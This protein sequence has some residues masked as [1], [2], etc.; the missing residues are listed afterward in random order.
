MIH[1]TATSGERE[2]CRCHGKMS[3]RLPQYQE[4]RKKLLGKHDLPKKKKKKKGDAIDWQRVYRE[5]TILG[6]VFPTGDAAMRT[7][8]GCQLASLRPAERSHNDSFVTPRCRSITK[9]S[10]A[11][12]GIEETKICFHTRSNL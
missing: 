4:R 10:T 1:A 5:G 12:R 9:G 7:L 2:T 11:L 3:I 8:T 6:S